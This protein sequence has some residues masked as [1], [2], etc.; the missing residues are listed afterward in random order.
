MRLAEKLARSERDRRELAKIE[1]KR[2]ADEVAKRATEQQ[3]RHLES[4][5]H[6]A[7]G[8]PGSKSRPILQETP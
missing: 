3:G 1:I 4:T 7:A 6:W 8:L 5:I 2:V